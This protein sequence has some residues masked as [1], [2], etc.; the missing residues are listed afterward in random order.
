M[1]SILLPRE[2]SIGECWPLARQ[3]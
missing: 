3:R 1:T 2:R